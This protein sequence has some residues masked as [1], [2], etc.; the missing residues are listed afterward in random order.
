MNH[1]EYNQQDIFSLLFSSQFLLLPLSLT[2]Q[3]WNVFSNV[4]F[5]FVSDQDF[6]MSKYWLSKHNNNEQK[7]EYNKKNHKNN[8]L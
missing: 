2:K 3:M 8:F 1:K 7:S 6:W 4:I 5:F